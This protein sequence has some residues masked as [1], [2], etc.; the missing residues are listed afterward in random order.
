M[1]VQ[2]LYR[3]EGCG[4]QVGEKVEQQGTLRFSWG[5]GRFEYSRRGPRATPAF[6]RRIRVFLTFLFQVVGMTLLLALCAR[7]TGALLDLLVE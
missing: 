1:G 5:P 7:N 2:G 3:V 6:H 4:F